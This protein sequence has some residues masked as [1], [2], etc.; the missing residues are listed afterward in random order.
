[1]FVIIGRNSR[2]VKKNID[3]GEGIYAISHRD[4]AKTDFT[5]ASRIYLFSWSHKDQ[6]ANLN[7]VRKL[8]IE[9]IIFIS[10]ASVLSLQIRQQW[11]AYPRWKKQ[12]E[13]IIIEN[14]GMVVRFGV[15]DDDLL[16]GLTGLVPFTSNLEIRNVLSKEF[17]VGNFVYNAF[18][19][20]PGR[21]YGLKKRFQRLF[22]II[23][24][25]LPRIMFFQAPLCVLS[26]RLKIYSYG[27]S[28]DSQKVCYDEIQCGFGV[29]GSTYSLG[30]KRDNRLIIITKEPDEKINSNGFCNTII[31][32]YKTGLAKS[33]H[34]VKI[35]R[36]DSGA[37]RKEV[38][39]LNL[40]PKVPRH[41][42]QGKVLR[43]NYLNG[44][45]N[46]E[47]KVNGFLNH[48]FCQRLVL[49]AGPI[50][51]VEILKDK[52]KTKVTFSDHETAIIGTLDNREAIAKGHI[53]RWLC[54]V[55]H[56]DVIIGMT[57]GFKCLIDVRPEVSVKHGTEDNPNAF[58]LQT[59]YSLVKKLI[60]GFSMMRINEALFNKLGIAFA[61]RRM[62]VC[63]QVLVEGCITRTPEGVYSR[64]R[65]SRENWDKIQIEIKKRFSTFEPLRNPLSADSQHIHGGSEVFSDH[66]I[67]QL[68][69]N[70][71]LVILGSPSRVRLG[72]AHHSHQIMSKIKSQNY[73]P[74]DDSA[75]F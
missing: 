10:T 41:S 53:K 47:V 37:Y 49:G 67:V 6:D 18:T 50:G 72:A 40:R 45:F 35:N 60:F 61:T 44:I 66:G 36:L 24:S 71:K 56:T 5:T 43:Y 42:V 55:Q 73:N 19:L 75:M 59:T 27:Y 54:F 12:V 17:L 70:K 62:S 1:M 34:G 64:Q 3:L 30:T 14:G 2:L 57:A 52:I 21:C 20:K 13:E 7:L 22:E 31:G 26:R 63:V 32:R 15:C 9:K 23:S 33:W 16:D 48:Y 65:I 68:I 58:Y 25:V 69:R 28:L 38:P 39:L 8:P 74:L 51:N 46:V 11:A 4:I 29:L